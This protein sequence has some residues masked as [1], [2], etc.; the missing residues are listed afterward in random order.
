VCIL[1]ARDGDSWIE[2]PFARVEWGNGNILLVS[3]FGL[4]RV[5]LSLNALVFAPN[6]SGSCSTPSRLTDR[7][8]LCACTGGGDLGNGRYGGTEPGTSWGRA[9]C[10]IGIDMTALP[11][12]ILPTLSFCLHP[13]PLKHSLL[14]WKC[15]GWFEVW[16]SSTSAGDQA[17]VAAST[18]APGNGD[19]RVQAL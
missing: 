8:A 1:T 9:G 3:G 14:Y 16:S 6:D 4:A 10:D 13:A 18:C 15:P 5:L 19:Y 11:V 17:E 7:V 2:G 12:L